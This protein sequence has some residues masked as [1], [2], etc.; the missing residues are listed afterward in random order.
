MLFQPRQPPF[1]SVSYDY[2]RNAKKWG[3]LGL[4]QR[5]VFSYCVTLMIAENNINHTQTVM[6]F[7]RFGFLLLA[8]KYVERG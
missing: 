4:K 8:S 7:L 3:L 2:A 1:L 6:L 5:F